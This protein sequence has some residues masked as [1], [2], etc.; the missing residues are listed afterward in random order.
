[1]AHH[2]TLS[3]RKLRAIELLLTPL[4]MTKVAEGAGISRRQLYRW[5]DE[6]D[7]AAALKAAKAE[8]AQRAITIAAGALVVATKTAVHLAEFS[9]D[10]STRL[11]AAVAVVDMHQR[12]SEH[13]DLEQ[14]I[15]ALEAVTDGR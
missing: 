12:M 2:D 8:A 1:M 14:R 10:E 6:P 7:F 4:D 13:L 11:R 15:A 3:A 5:I 9:E